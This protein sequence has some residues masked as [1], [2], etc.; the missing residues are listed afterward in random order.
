MLPTREI[1]LFIVFFRFIARAGRKVVFFP[2]VGS[3]QTNERSIFGV[4][5][6]GFIRSEKTGSHVDNYY[7]MR[8]ST[9]VRMSIVNKTSFNNKRVT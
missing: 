1:L 7:A 8:C 2:C 9:P 6:V 5:G 4:E 3:H